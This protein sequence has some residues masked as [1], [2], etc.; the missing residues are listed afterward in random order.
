MR[1]SGLIEHIKQ[2]GN[3]AIQSQSG[4]VRS[5]KSD[6]SVVTAVD[7]TINRGLSRIILD[8]YPDASLIAEE[9]A[10]SFYNPDCEYTFVLDP[11]DGTDTYSMGMP[12]WCIALGLL[13]NLEPV[14]GIVYAPCWGPG[15]SLLVAEEDGGV[16]LN[17]EP[18][19]PGKQTAYPMQI[20]AP[21]TAHRY[22]D[23]SGFYGKVRNSGSSIVSMASLILHSQISGAV[24]NTSFIW[25]IAASHAMIKKLGF[26]LEYL[27]G[28]KIEYKELVDRSP[29]RNYAVCGT[30]EAL[31][32]IRKSFI[33]R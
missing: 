17:G 32:A 8:E 16:T 28:K 33:Y 18:L 13:R 12:G 4:T 26:E 23:Y 3:F 5:F 7:L 6:G 30:P 2:A 19:V 15:G 14:G 24:I 21:S 10:I 9:E 29:L 27:S 25:D 11:L 20:M 1:I 31:A 22:F